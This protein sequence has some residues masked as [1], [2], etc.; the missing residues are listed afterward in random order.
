MKKL[1]LLFIFILFLGGISALCEG[2]QIDINTASSEELDELYGIGPVK[3]EA[4]INSRSFESIDELINVNGIGEITLNKIK[5]QG[6][7]CVD[8]EIEEVNETVLIKDEVVEE[9]VV[10]EEEEEVI[11]EEIIE[12]EIKEIELITLTA[13]TIKSQDNKENK[14]NYAMYGFVAFSILLV[15]LFILKKKKYKNEF[16]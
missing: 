11:E 15:V 9:S 6:L 16:R 1:I 4:I 10:E 7:A 3:A 14:S 5:E 12:T 13:K 2:G 8:E